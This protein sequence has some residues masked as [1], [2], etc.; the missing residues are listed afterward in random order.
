LVVA[1][2]EP[3]PDVAV[4]E[5]PLASDEAAALAFLDFFTFFLPLAFALGV[6]VSVAVAVEPPVV[7]VAAEPVVVVVAL[8]LGLLDGVAGVAF[9]ASPLDG[10]AAEPCAAATPAVAANAAAITADSTLFMSFSSN[11]FVLADRTRGDKRAAMR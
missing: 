3:V 1:L 9:I 2:A 6:A 10:A 4:D 7:A 8:A 5:A 11:G